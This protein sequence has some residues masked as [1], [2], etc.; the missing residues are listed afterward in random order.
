MVDQTRSFELFSLV[1]LALA[2]LA[3]VG[4]ASRARGLLAGSLGVLVAMPGMH[5]AT[6]ELR[7]TF[8][9]TSLNEGFRLIPVLI[10]MFAIG[11]IL[12]DLTGKDGPVEKVSGNDSAWIEPGLWKNQLLNLFRSSGI[13][14]IGVLL[15]V[16]ANIG[17]L[18]AYMAAN[19]L[20]T[21]RIS[22]KEVKKASSPLGVSQQCHRGGALIPLIALGVPGSVIRAGCPAWSPH[23]SR[24]TTRTFAFQAKP[25]CGARHH[26]NRSRS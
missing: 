26:R 11:K 7:W 3:G 13:G 20:R 9:F 15:G 19:G 17:S 22:G 4:D 25:R 12:E 23:R 21:S 10:G 6:G 18:A 24:P 16:G 5:P 1:I 2:L 8:G 14:T